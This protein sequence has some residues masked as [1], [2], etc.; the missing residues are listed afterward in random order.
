VL[1]I[2]VRARCAALDRRLDC[3]TD[4][5]IAVA[6]QGRTVAGAEVDIL[7]AIEVPHA[8]AGGAVEVEGVTDGAVD[9][10]G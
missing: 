2:L 7:A 5:W 4:A 6:K 10:R 3:P 1:F 8:A 9:A